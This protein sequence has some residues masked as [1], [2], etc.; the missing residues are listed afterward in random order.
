MTCVLCCAVLCCAVLACQVEALTGQLGKMG[1]AGV[2][3]KQGVVLRGVPAPTGKYK[4][5]DEE[6]D[7][8]ASK[9]G[10][11]GAKAAAGAGG[12]TVPRNR[13][14]ALRG[15]APPQGK[16]ISFTEDE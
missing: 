14:V 12:R 13:P 5:F 4:R 9:A 2:V 6:E 8:A 3:H 15:V 16:H 11:A 7:V 1:V 10:A